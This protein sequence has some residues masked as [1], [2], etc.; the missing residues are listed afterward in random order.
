MKARFP[1]SGNSGPILR[2]CGKDHGL[3]QVPTEFQ[4]GSS[5]KIP[6]GVFGVNKEDHHQVLKGPICW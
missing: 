4:S 6:A 3:W 2:A 1:F 5:R